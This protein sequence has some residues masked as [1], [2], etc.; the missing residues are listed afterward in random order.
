MNSLTKLVALAALAGTAPTLAFAQDAVE[1]D[2]PASME[3]G[4]TM[5]AQDVG[6][7]TVDEIEAFDEGRTVKIITLEQAGGDAEGI[8]GEGALG[9][10]ID[11]QAEEFD[12]IV[13]AIDA[14]AIIADQLDAEGYSGEDIIAVGMDPEGALT[15][16]VGG[17][18]EGAQ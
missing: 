17:E 2:P 3:E 10:M 9:E 5:S 15:I 4:Q 14:N 7:V 1:A 16:M 11:Q 12:A 6:P 13:A 8:P 18:P